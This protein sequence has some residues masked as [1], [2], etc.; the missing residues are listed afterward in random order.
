MSQCN[1]KKSRKDL[2][3]FLQR[4]AEED[5]GFCVETAAVVQLLSMRSCCCEECYAGVEASLHGRIDQE[6]DVLIEIVAILYDHHHWE[7]K[8]TARVKLAPAR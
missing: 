6:Q 5:S 8:E 4:M 3:A 2:E 7:F 1:C